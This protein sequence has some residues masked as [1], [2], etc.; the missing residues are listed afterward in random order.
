MLFLPGQLASRADFYHQLG[1]MTSAGLSLTN[2]LQ[3]LAR[4]YRSASF[5]SQLNHALLDIEAGAT[6]SESFRRR[7]GWLPEFDI[8]LLHAG[9]RSGRLDAT[10]T[11]LATYYGDRAAMARKLL[12]AVAYPLLLIHL[13]LFILPFADFFKT[14]NA[15]AYLSKSVGPLLVIYALIGLGI[16]LSQSNR[17]FAWRGVFETL[18]GFIPL[19]GSGRRSLAIGR[20]AGAMEALINAGETIHEA[21]PLAAAACGSPT[22]QHEVARWRSQFALGRTPAEVMRDSPVIPEM[23]ANLYSSGEVSG[24]LDHTLR[25]LRDYFNDEGSRTLHT[26]ARVWPGVLYGLVALYIAY[27]VISFYSGYFNQV[28]QAIGGN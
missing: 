20:L 7:E 25:R 21:W 5:R 24:Q 28:N 11:T 10:F 12:S 1:Q 17:S 18:T 8:A 14:G 9:E 2:S 16:F 4:T 3:T 23:F 6:V 19:V 13:A 15:V 27:Q 22:L 26:A